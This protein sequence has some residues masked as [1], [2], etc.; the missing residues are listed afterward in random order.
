VIIILA[1]TI[2]T[3]TILFPVL[4]LLFCLSFYIFFDAVLY[5]F[6]VV[7]ASDGLSRDKVK[8]ILLNI[9]FVQD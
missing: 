1:C 4:A 7:F 3:H 5:L 6:Y 9:N 8:T 2:F